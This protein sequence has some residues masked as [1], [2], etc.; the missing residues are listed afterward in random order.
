MEKKACLARQTCSEGWWWE[1]LKSVP[2]GW[3]EYVLA[4]IYWHKPSW[5]HYSHLLCH[6][7]MNVCHAFWKAFETAAVFLPGYARACELTLCAFGCCIN[8]DAEKKQHGTRTRFIQTLWNCI[9]VTAQ[10]HQNFMSEGWKMDSQHLHGERNL[11]TVKIMNLRY[12]LQFI[13]SP[14]HAGFLLQALCVRKV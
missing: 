8:E 11:A 6:E 5:N 9:T 3:R 12:L 10:F 4:S 7:W 2:F 14:W 13:I 1:C